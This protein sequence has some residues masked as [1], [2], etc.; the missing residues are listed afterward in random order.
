MKKTHTY[1]RAVA[2]FVR[3]A[4]IATILT[5]KPMHL[6]EGDAWR[7]AGKRKGKRAR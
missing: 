4:A 1:Y 6:N 2:I 7:R 5:A 3:S